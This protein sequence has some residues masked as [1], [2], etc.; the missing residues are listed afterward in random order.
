METFPATQEP[1]EGYSEHPLN[2]SVSG[3]SQDNA[4]T[5][6]L[7]SSA[8]IPAWLLSQMPRLTVEEKKRKPAGVNLRATYHREH[9]LIH[10]TQ[11]ISPCSY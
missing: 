7:R 9:T 1:D 11:Q 5:L 4:T 8:E 10:V 3:S 2:T 6:A